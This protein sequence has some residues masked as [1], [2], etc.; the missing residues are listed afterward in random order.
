M[1]VM[2]QHDSGIKKKVKMGF[3]WTVFF[4]GFFVPLLRGDYKWALILFLFASIAGSAS[5][6]AGGLLVSIVFAFL[7]NK[8][9]IKG[10][11]EKGYRPPV[12]YEEELYDYVG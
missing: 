11:L 9:Y 10:L 8:I 7:Y 4:F 6:G 12:S 5:E 2:M 1:E 3:S